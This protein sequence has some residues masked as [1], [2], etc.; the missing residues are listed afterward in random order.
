[1]MEEGE[2]RDN[3][4]RGREF[5]AGGVVLKEGRVL[6]VRARNLKGD[7][8]WTFPKG[9][10]EPGETPREAALR[11]VEE[12][13]GWRCRILKT[14]MTARYA[15]KREGRLI[16]KRVQWYWM[17]AGAKLGDRDAAEIEAVRWSSLE[18]A[19]GLLRYPSD[20]SLLERTDR[21]LK[22]GRP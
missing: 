12:E 8:V 11:E 7:L 13:T 4:G 10:V 20:L 21:F 17:E 14:A 6:L 3:D 2:G 19:A 9:H 5:S 16:A 22:G 15:F 18:K 1:M